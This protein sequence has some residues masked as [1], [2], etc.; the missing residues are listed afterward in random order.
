[1]RFDIPVDG[2]YATLQGHRRVDADFLFTVFD[3]IT[4]IAWNVFKERAGD[5]CYIIDGDDEI[6]TV[7]D[8]ST[9]SV[10]NM[11]VNHDQCDHSLSFMFLSENEE[12]DW[13][14]YFR[15]WQRWVENGCKGDN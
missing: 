9:D 3:D 14:E 5:G 10:F 12:N 4:S 13:I 2:R 8:T 1:M 15:S 7:L 11:I 6:M